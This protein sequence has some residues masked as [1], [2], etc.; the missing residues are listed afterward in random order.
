LTTIIHTQSQQDSLT[1]LPPEL[2]TAQ[3]YR[4]GFAQSARRPPNMSRLH[5]VER[6]F[7]NIA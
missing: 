4:S 6:D 2:S 1:I 5:I 3:E 7:L